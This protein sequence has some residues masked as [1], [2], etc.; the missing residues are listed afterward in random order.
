VNPGVTG[1]VSQTLE[2]Y[3]LAR[4]LLVKHARVA[5]AK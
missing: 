1:R 2:L 5:E 3:F 4:Q